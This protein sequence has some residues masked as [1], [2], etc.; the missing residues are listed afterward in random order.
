M[1][2]H[3]PIIMKYDLENAK[4]DQSNHMYLMVIK[5]SVVEAIRVLTVMRLI[6]T[7]A[8]GASRSYITRRIVRSS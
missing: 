3:A 7:L 1:R 2:D 8:S 5:S 4:W 6:G